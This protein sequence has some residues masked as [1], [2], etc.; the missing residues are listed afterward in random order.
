MVE[1][2]KAGVAMIVQEAATLP[3]IDVASNIFIGNYELFSKNGH[4]DVKKMH[5]EADKILKEIGVED[6]KGSTLLA[7]H[8]HLCRKLRLLR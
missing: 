8:R 2:Q 1:A 3:T 4:L 6:I 7:D 5:R